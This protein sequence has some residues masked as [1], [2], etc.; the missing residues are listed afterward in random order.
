MLRY[1]LALL[2]LGVIWGSNFIFMKWSTLLITPMQT[3]LLRVLFGF[4]PL[5]I[6]A[7]YSKQLQLSQLKHLFH[8]M[9]MS[10]LAT[11]FYYYGFVAGTDLIPTSV[12]GLL[13]GSIP[14]FTFICAFLFLRQD[15][16]TLQMLM[17]VIVGFTG[18]IISA[19]PWEGTEGVNIMGVL[20]MLAGTTSLGIS[21]VYAQ[22]QLSP[23]KLPPLVLATWQTGCATVTLLILTDLSGISHLAADIKTVL[24][25]VLGLGVLGTGAAFFLYYYAIEKLGSVKASGATYIAPLVAVIIG[26]IVGEDMNSS[27]VIAFM[28]ILGGVILIQTGKPKA[29]P[30]QAADIDRHQ[31]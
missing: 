31:P 2:L 22:R 4:L 21:F 29:S 3:V 20:W 11:T 23:L 18:I 6:V 8:F 13:S 10:V 16:P 1:Y 7:G 17:G 14:I 9:V 28:L 24:G 12:A 5:L 30:I 27:I 26:A 19:R 25:V 15:R